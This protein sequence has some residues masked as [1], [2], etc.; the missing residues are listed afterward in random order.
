MTPKFI[1]AIERK[2]YHLRVVSIILHFTLVSVAT[3]GYYFPYTDRTVV[4]SV[5]SVPY[6][7]RSCKMMFPISNLVLFTVKT[8]MCVY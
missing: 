3:G 5:D 7:T 2:L 6:T 4:D 8:T 1:T